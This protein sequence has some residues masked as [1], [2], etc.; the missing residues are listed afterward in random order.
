MNTI[1]NMRYYTKVAEVPESAKKPIKAGRLA[2]FTDINPMWRI[3]KLTEL[4][5]AAGEGWTTRN[6]RFST[7]E[8][9]SLKTVALLCEL[10]LVYRLEDGTW[11]EPVYGVGGN[12][13]VADER[14]GARMDDDA[15]KKAYTDALSIACKAL[16]FGANVY[17]K[18]GGSK[19]VS[20]E[21][22]YK[23]EQPP[24][25]TPTAGM[26]AG[27]YIKQE[28]AAMQMTS[29]KLVGCRNALIGAG[30]VKDIPTSR[31]TMQEA[32]EFVTALRA[33]FR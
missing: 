18:E 2:G 12:T 17:W 4:F 20:G 23:V 24:Q 3:Q 33:N 31:M 19:Y 7:Y 29:Q 27:Q 26:T 25:S 30:L 21:P 8:N 10:E 16:G 1:H 5:G 32:Q 22:S 13:L 28:V 9:T 6:V 15:W 11:S 14:N